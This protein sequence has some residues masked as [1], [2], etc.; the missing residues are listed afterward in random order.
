MA[1]ARWKIL[2]MTEITER[3]GRAWVNQEWKGGICPASGDRV[4]VTVKSVVNGEI[5][6]I[7]MNRVYMNIV[8]VEDGV[9]SAWLD[10]GDCR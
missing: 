3:E 1:R 7:F 8:R 10:A 4:D 9:Q 2:V 6:Y 5:E